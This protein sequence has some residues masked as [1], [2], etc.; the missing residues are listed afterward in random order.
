MRN[1]R[2]RIRHSVLFEL[3]GLI[4]VTPLGGWAFGVPISHFG[5]VAVV[6]TSLAMGWNY[7]YNL[8]FDHA[9]LRIYGDVRKSLRARIVHAGLFEFG[10]LCLLV[11]FIAWYLDVPLWQAFVMDVSLAGF[12]LVYAFVFN[13]IYDIVFPIPAEEAAA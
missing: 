13:W 2:D 10:L 5:I 3:I 1:T 11:P 7:A 9:M 12:Y 4:T 8:G 6:S